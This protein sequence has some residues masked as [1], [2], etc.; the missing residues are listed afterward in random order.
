MILAFGKT[1]TALWTTTVVCGI[2][3]VTVKTVDATMLR[4]RAIEQHVVYIALAVARFVAVWAGMSHLFPCVEAG[5]WLVMSSYETVACCCCQW[6]RRNSHRNSTSISPSGVY[7]GPSCP[8][9]PISKS[10]VLPCQQ[11]SGL[12]MRAVSQRSGVR[13]SADCTPTPRCKDGASC[14]WL[15]AGRDDL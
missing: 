3:L 7:C 8:S 14:N 4:L 9:V 10:P 1:R 5:F 2:F 13:V 6:P 12:L 11:C 15:G